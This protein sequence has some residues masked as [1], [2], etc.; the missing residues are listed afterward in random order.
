MMIEDGPGLNWLDYFILGT[1]AAQLIQVCLFP[2]PSAGST[3]EMLVKVRK[4]QALSVNHP[5]KAALQSTSKTAIL[6]T[7]TLTVGAS[8]LIPLL[9]LFFPQVEGYLLP[10]VASPP[11]AL[12]I[13]SAILLAGGNILTFIAVGTLRSH[14]TFHAFGETARLYTAGVYSYLRHPI[15][16]G[17]GAIFAGF[18]LAVPSGVL[19]IGVIVFWCNSHYRVKM[20]EVYLHRTFGEEYR[21]YTNRVGKYFPKL[22]PGAK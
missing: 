4:D 5:A 14:V 10:L 8:A 9:T 22:R 20:E 17:L 3:L 16:L 19:M 15:T 13:M 1:Y 18:V 21:Q 12:K 2:V 11:P 6:L 7:A